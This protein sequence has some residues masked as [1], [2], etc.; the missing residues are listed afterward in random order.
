MIQVVPNKQVVGIVLAGGLARRMGGGDKGLLDLGGRPVLD[1]VLNRLQPQVRVV[2]LNANGDLSRFSQWNISIASDTLPGN[3]GPLAG[4]LAGLDWVTANLPGLTWIVTVPTDAPFIPHNLVARLL[5]SALS[6]DAEIACATSRSRRHPV[7]A[8]W[9]AALRG[10]LRHALLHDG[11]RKV[12]DWTCH[13]R[14]IDVAFES[15]GVDPFFNINT[16]ED[17]DVARSALATTD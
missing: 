3:H 14:T 12:E 7:V 5:D 13:Y 11:V 2:V 6:N 4:V 15:E 17:L 16:A 10:D 9:S 1:C 8:L